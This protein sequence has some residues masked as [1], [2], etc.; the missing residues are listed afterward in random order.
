MRA[1]DEVAPE[2][3]SRAQ[4]PPPPAAYPVDGELWM[5]VD[6]KRTRKRVKKKKKGK[7]NEAPGACMDAG[8]TTNLNVV[9]PSS[10]EREARS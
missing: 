10:C 6:S 2:G 4:P 3:T 7:K 8:K 1:E 9:P 5:E